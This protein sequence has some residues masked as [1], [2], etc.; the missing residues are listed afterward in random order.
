MTAA[1]SKVTL[2][3]VGIALFAAGVAPD[4]QDTPVMSAMADEL[5]RSMK[6]LRMKDQPAPYYIEYEV[7]DRA[8]TRV[9]ARLGALTEDLTGISRTLRVGVRIGDY[10]FDSSLFNAPGLS[11]GGVVEL[12]A[13]GSISAPLDD[14]YDTMRRQIWLA[15]DAAYKRAVSTFCLLYTSPSPRD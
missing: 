14:D 15:T 9:T 11:G 5:A 2:A 10:D 7:W 12:S 3:A 1:T 13:D 4:A 8:Q 6:E